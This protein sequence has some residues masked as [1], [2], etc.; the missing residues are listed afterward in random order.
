MKTSEAQ[1]RASEKYDA[2]N[3]KQIMLKLNTKTDKDILERLESVGNK[4]GYIK[5][6]IR[7]DMEAVG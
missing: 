3:T 2:E 1:R 7:K 4:Q 6:L 5:R